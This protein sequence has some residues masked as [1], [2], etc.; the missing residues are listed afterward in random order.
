MP[1][2]GAEA[3]P[4]MKVET[5]VKVLCGSERLRYL[6]GATFSLVCGAFVCFCSA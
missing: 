6:E 1:Q 5:S 4:N 2:D 3:L